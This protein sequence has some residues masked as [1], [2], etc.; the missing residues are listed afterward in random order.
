MNNKFLQLKQE[1]K[2]FLFNELDGNNLDN[3]HIKIEVIL[4][5]ICEKY[6]KKFNIELNLVE[7]DLENLFQVL[8][9]RWCENCG[10]LENIYNGG[11]TPND[12]T[13]CDDCYNHFKD[14]EENDED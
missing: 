8:E 10:K 1:E 12:M 3:F 4:N 7:S 14:D 2:E 11:G 9:L 13:C 5:D 6:N